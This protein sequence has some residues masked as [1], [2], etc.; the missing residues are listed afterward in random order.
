MKNKYND[1]VEKETV[2]CLK[3]DSLGVIRKVF[4]DRIGDGEPGKSY[5]ILKSLPPRG[6]SSP[7]L[8]RE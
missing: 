3:E 7:Q 6:P 4:V 5:E 2:D 1:F 8:L